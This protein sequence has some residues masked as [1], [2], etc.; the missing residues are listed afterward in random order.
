MKPTLAAALPHLCLDHSCNVLEH[1]ELG[2]RLDEDFYTHGVCVFRC[3]I[4]LFPVPAGHPLH[5][6]LYANQ[7]QLD[8]HVVAEQLGGLLGAR[9]RCDVDRCRERLP[10]IS[11]LLKLKH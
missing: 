2:R 1:L 3:P 4:S 8:T 7:P 5:L 6:R 9:T 11:S 10:H